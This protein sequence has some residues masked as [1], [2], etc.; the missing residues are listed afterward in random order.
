[1]PVRRA[2]RAGDQF[3]VTN[4]YRIEA[5]GSG[6][7]A[8]SSSPLNEQSPVMLPDG[9]ILYHRWEYLD[10]PAGNIKSLWAM[11]PDGSGRSRCTAIA[12]R[13]PKR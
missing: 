1:M 3:T 12:S 5:D 4:L 7:R 2:V 10:K 6:M 8:L 13:F 9:R 11:N